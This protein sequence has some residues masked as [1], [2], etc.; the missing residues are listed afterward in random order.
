MI[1]PLGLYRSHRFGL[2]HTASLVP[3]MGC[4]QSRRQLN[5]DDLLPENGSCFHVDILAQTRFAANHFPAR[6]EIRS[7][8]RFGVS[9]LIPLPRMTL[10][11]G[12]LEIGD[13]QLGVV[14]SAT[15]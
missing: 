15:G 10:L 7:V 13:G 5:G 14:I 6:V 11:V 2:T 8:T 4:R 9:P 12:P 3:A 1:S